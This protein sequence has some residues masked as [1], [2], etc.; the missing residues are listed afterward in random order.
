LLADARHKRQY[1]KLQGNPDG[2]SCE[3]GLDGFQIQSNLKI[4]DFIWDKATVAATGNAQS[5]QRNWATYGVFQDQLTFVASYGGNVTPTWKIETVVLGTNSPLL[6]ATRTNT[7]TLTITMGPLDLSSA[8]QN[9]PLALKGG[10]ASQH[11]AAAIGTAV[12]GANQSQS[13]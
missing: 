5:T 2:P 10:A 12:G 4:D 13:H 3:Q 9:T 1:D 7:D 8:T 6:S 11:Q